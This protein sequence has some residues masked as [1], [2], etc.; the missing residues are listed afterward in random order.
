MQKV[1]N[2]D[3]HVHVLFSILQGFYSWN[4]YCDVSI[5]HKVEENLNIWCLNFKLGTI[6]HLFI[7]VYGTYFK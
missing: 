1:N 4:T 2:V 6:T 7:K 3:I 5:N